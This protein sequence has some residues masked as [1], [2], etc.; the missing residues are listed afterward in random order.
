MPWFFIAARLNLRIPV[1]IYGVIVDQPHRLHESIANCRTDEFETA[2]GQVFA[3]GIRFGRLCRHLLDGLPGIAARLPAG[4]PPDIRI[5]A[6]KFGLNRQ[7]GTRIGDRSG[8][9]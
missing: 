6:A 9:F 4:K 1:A 7:E 3:H 8:H 2:P 5:E